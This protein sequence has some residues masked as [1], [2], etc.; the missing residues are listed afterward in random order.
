MNSQSPHS[1]SLLSHTRPV[2]WTSYDQK[3]AFPE[4]CYL[5][6]LRNTNPGYTRGPRD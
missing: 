3:D 6:C 5:D 2:S 1:P 4:D